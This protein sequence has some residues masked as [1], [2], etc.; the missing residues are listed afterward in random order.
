LTTALAAGNKTRAMQYLSA[1]AQIKYGPVFDALLPH[2]QQIVGGFSSLQSAT[3]VGGYGEYAVNRTIN[4]VNGI[5]FVY[6]MQSD[7]GVWRLDAM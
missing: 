5:F 3:L 4:G 6:F 7:V 2:M 1:P